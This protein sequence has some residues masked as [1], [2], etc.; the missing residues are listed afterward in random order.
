MNIIIGNLS[1]ASKLA[2]L[3]YGNQIIS[4]ALMFVEAKVLTNL[5]DISDYGAYNQV[6]TTASLV[7]TVFSLNLGHGF[8]RFASGFPD[9]KKKETFHTV[10]LTQTLLYLFA[11]LLTLPVGLKISEFLTDLKV[12]YP[13]FFIGLL[14]IISGG[15]CNIQNFLLVSGQDV[16]MLL[17]NLYK[18]IIDVVFIIA[19]VLIIPSLFGALFGYLLGELFCFFFFSI[20]NK[21]KYKGINVHIEILKEL[22]RFSLPLMVTSIAYWIITS[23]NRYIINYYLGLESV[24]QF[25]IANRLPMM[26]VTI[27]T[28]L[29]TIFLSN[30]ARLFDSGNIKRTSYWFTQ[31]IKVYILIGVSGSALLVVA[32]RFITLILST[33]QYLFPDIAQF[34]IWLCVGS[35]CF[36]LFQIISKIYDLEKKVKII[37]I[38]WGIILILNILLNFIFIP[39]FGLLG[40]SWSSAITFLTGLILA[41][42]Y[43]PKQIRFDF[44]WI[45]ITI[46]VVLSLLFSSFFTT[47]MLKHDFSIWVE[48][49]FSLVSFFIVFIGGLF[50]KIIS[51]EE[52]KELIYKKKNSSNGL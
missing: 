44:S 11:F 5:L 4:M 27:F 3:S 14:A 23:S 51:V 40:S 46:Y 50:M 47:E 30:T 15:I 17:Q 9:E 52:L 42:V 7:T 45:N 10:L 1:K 49:I 24:G 33:P 48:A 12:I 13:V 25:A 26:I 29:S 41:L 32:H 22:L 2:F 16:K 20:S 36:G 35:I 19:A 38:F 34:Y 43:R 31:M 37:S 18:T 6:L 21:I 39:P 28:L 8:I